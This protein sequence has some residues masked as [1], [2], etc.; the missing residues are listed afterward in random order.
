MFGAEKSCVAMQNYMIFIIL[1]QAA[2]ESVISESHINYN[3]KDN[4]KKKKKRM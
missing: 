3:C 2:A 4:Q 1:L